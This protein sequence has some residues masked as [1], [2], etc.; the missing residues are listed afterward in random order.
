MLFN[1]FEFLVFL[2]V[3]FFGYYLP[4]FSRHQTLLLCIAS[5]IFYAW[6]GPALLF[7]LLSSIILNSIL[8]FS[9][10][11][12]GRKINTKIILFLGVAI[13]LG[14][15]GFFKYAGF[16]SSFFWTNEELRHD[17][18]GFF[19]LSVPLPIGISF[20]TF[21]GVSL[22]VDAYRNRN[23]PAK[24][25]KEA[26]PNFK[27]QLKRVAL[28]ISF[29]PQLV[30]G[31]IVKA[32]DF[33]PQIKRKH[34]A[35]IPWWPVLKF[36][37]LGY[38]MKTVLADNLKEA[39]T[40]MTFPYFQGL[41]SITLISLLLGYSIQIFSDFAGYS[42][43]AIGLGGLFGYHLPGNFNF[44]YISS[45]FSEFW[46]R[47]HISL[48]SWLRE[49]LYIPLGG[50]RKGSTR[51]YVNLMIVMFLGGLWHGAAWSYAIWG[52]LHGLALATERFIT[53]H[54][55]FKYTH[56]P[57][58]IS[59]RIVFVFSIVSLAWLF[60]RLPSF[61]EALS[62]FSAAIYNWNIS[63]KF[64]LIFVVFVFGL[65]VVA[66]HLHHLCLPSK[67]YQKL[68]QK[69]EPAIYSIMFFAIIFNRG[70]SGAFIYFQF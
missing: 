38:F 50:N 18:I 57:I 16:F 46:T 5:F 69:M 15:L 3:C 70:P 32:N 2:S 12:M 4:A 62:Y 29:F 42:L 67:F 6:S 30:A 36:L 23:D 13:N 65:P 34:L 49:Y 25:L 68:Y 33:I 17:P 37:I 61:E 39:T 55:K 11:S 20:Y 48:S 19:I 14:I 64:G 51:T 8:S 41:S 53:N 58:V 31:P 24:Q 52:S 66:H 45:S 47:W 43:I 9:F 40:W 56:H 63:T 27:T 10:V 26:S 28:F 44:P 7:L 60:F 59:L 54:F 22:I 1:S 35:D 21:Q